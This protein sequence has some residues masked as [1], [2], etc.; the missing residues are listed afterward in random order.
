M[1][2]GQRQ[3]WAAARSPE[4]EVIWYRGHRPLKVWEPL[5]QRIASSQLGWRRQTKSFTS[6]INGGLSLHCDVLEIPN[7]PESIKNTAIKLH[8]ALQW[9]LDNRDFDFIF[10]TNSSTYVDTQKLL[11]HVRN[12]PRSSYLAGVVGELN[13][14]QFPSG[15]GILMSRDVAAKLCASGV[16]LTQTVDDVAVGGGAK[17]LGLEIQPIRRLDVSDCQAVLELTELQTS[18]T[19]FYR[20]KNSSNR[21]LGEQQTMACLHRRLDAPSM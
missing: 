13:G 18:E 7:I 20:C 10:R 17:S 8:V 6:Y 2:L 19:L 1:E 12:A 5:R 15:T 9:S 16:L 21:G 4:I 11:R 3:T 14:A